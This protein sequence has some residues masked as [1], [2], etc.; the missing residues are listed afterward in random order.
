MTTWWKVKKW[1]WKALIS[2]SNLLDYF[3]GR[4][5]KASLCGNIV[6]CNCLS[7]LLLPTAVAAIASYLV[8][9]KRKT[10]YDQDSILLSWMIYCITLP[11]SKSHWFHVSFDGGTIDDMDA[12]DEILTHSICKK[13]L[14]FMMGISN[15]QWNS[16][17]QV[18]LYSFLVS[19][20]VKERSNAAIKE[21]DP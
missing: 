16:I 7:I 20:D 18:S 3:E 10:K 12:I 14:Q 6:C 4:L 11:G 17:R 2:N 13:G 8:S 19:V 1:K 9:F 15:L 21:D 5:Y